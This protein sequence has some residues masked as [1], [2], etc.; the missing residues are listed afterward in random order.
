MIRAASAG[1]AHLAE[2]DPRIIAIAA[3]HPVAAGQQPV[4]ELS[5]IA[6]IADFVEAATGLISKVEHR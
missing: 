1:N 5:D 6:G 4:F 3:D 2:T